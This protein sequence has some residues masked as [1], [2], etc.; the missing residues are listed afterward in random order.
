MKELDGQTYNWDIIDDLTKLP[1]FKTA[2]TDKNIP[3]EIIELRELIANASGVL[4]STPEYVFSIPS[5]L[6]NM[7]E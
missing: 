3:K 4:I 6:K 1:H 5:G 2:L 7:V